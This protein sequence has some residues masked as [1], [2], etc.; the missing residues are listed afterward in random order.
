[1]TRALFPAELRNGAEC[2][3]SVAAL[4]DF[5]VGEELI[6]T[7]DARVRCAHDPVRRIADEQAIRLAREH[8][9][10]LQH[11]ARAEEVVDLRHLRGELVRIALRETTRDDELLARAILLQLRELED[12]VDRFFFRLADEAA[13]VDDDDLRVFRFGTIS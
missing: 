5:H 11:V 4:R 7:E 6:L 1:M 10:E 8:V 13:R 9:T 3:C 2:T 12:G